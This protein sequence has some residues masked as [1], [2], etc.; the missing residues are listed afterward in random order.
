MLGRFLRPRM[1]GLMIG[2]LSIAVLG[3]ACSDDKATPTTRAT[4]AVST[5]TAPAP[6]ATAP[7]P[8][9]TI[10]FQDSQWSTLWI[11]NAL[12]MYIVDNGY[13]YPVEEIQ[14]TTGTMKVALA[15]GDVDVMMEPWRMNIPEWYQDEVV[16]SGNIVDLAGSNDNLPA[17]SKGQVIAFGGQA[18][19]IPRYVQEANPGLVSVFDLPDYAHLFKDPEDPDKG[20]MYNCIIGWQCQKIN[21]AKWYA[22]GLYDTF[23]VTEAGT[24]AALDANLS[25]AYEAEEAILSYYWEPTKLM[26]ELD[27]VPLEEPVWTQE[28]DDAMAAAVESEPYESEVGC[29]Y[30]TGDVHVMVHNSLVDR[31][32]E[33]TEF[34]SNVFVGKKVLAELEAYKGEN[35]ADW[36][37]VGIH[38]LQ[39]NRDI[40]S[41]W[42]AE[43]DVLAAVDAALALES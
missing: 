9:E 7:A 6:T 12:A 19:Y 10:I 27:F 4:V 20:V 33:V 16:T 11:H 35:D 17:G 5:A 25:G 37:D 15:Q 40:W 36:S 34:L 1:L 13:G 38:W 8:K 23:N 24:A 26:A 41:T 43:A 14:G 21:R 22:Y 42:I 39:E 2:L 3:A 29:G 30:P 28:C 31:A 32:P 18:F